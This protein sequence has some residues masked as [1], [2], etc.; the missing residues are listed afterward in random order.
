MAA[1][2]PY[3]I[4]EWF[5]R[6][7]PADGLVGGWRREGYANGTRDGQDNQSGQ[8]FVPA[9]SSDLLRCN[10]KGRRLSE[11]DTAQ[12][13]APLKRGRPN[14]LSREAI[15]E[16]TI[17]LL[18]EPDLDN[19]S[20]NLVSKRLSAGVMSLYTYFPSRDVLLR[21]A[22]DAIYSRFEQPA[23][24]ECWQEQVRAWLRETVR[25]LDRYPVA[26]KL[27]VW[28]GHVSAAWLRT[29]LPIVAVIKGQGLEGLRLAK[30]VSWFSTMAMGFIVVQTRSP[31]HPYAG[32]IENIHLLDKD[33]QSLSAELSLHFPAVD[34]DET[35]ELG[36]DVI[37]Y[38]LEK[39]IRDVG[40]AL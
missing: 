21:A 5:N 8:L 16:A 14:R 31:D 40:E 27:V 38:G 30:A 29:W 1:D 26:K 23:P 7:L 10:S 20:M 6:S 36:F 13:P 39:L 9:S 4:R 22:A 3:G 11:L 18:A 34:R 35:L 32:T 17:S 19:F 37:I 24:V 15:I 28:D 33:Q 25:L 12:L 2:Y